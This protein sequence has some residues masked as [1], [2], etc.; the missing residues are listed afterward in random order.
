MFMADGGFRFEAG[1]STSLGRQ[2]VPSGRHVV[3]PELIVTFHLVNSI[4]RD[5]TPFA[6]V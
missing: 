3:P 2:S 4:A 5:R 6:A 1:T